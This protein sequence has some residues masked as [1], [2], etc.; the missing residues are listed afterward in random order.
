MA[1]N[2]KTITV[3]VVDSQPAI[4]DLIQGVLHIF[5]V[6][7]MITRTDGKKGLHAFEHHRP[8]LLIVDWDL[9]SM[10]GLEFT[11]TVRR[12]A[13]NPY[14]PILFMTGLSSERRVTMARDCGVTEFLKKPFT[15]HSLYKRIEEIVERPRKFVRAP[16]FFGP[17]RRRKRDIIFGPDKREPAAMDID[18]VDSPEE[19]T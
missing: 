19:E 15:A 5:G 18:F 16:D 13:S 4:V 10:D 3:L 2:F 1:Y 14:A 6:R 11:R 8:D 9:A 7:K 12:S 17:D